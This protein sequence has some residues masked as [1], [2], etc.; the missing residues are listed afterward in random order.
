MA[1]DPI[2]I[3][4]LD[5]HQT[6]IDGYYYRLETA[7]GLRV[8]G[9]ARTGE[10]LE[11]L[12]ARE[13]ADVLLLDVAV[14]T[15]PTNSNSY[16]VLFAVPHLQARYPALSV[17][18]ISMHLDVALT[19]ALLES[20]ASGYILKDDAATIRVLP[21]VV[22]TVAA[23]GVHLSARVAQLLQQQAGAP[24]EALLTRR[25]HEVL[26]LCAAYPGEPGAQLAARLGVAP[27]TL[28]NLLSGA[29]ARLGVRN[30]VE[31]L[32]R[33]RELRLITPLTSD[34]WPPPDQPAP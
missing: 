24:G 16:P 1:I 14:P 11:A 10:E 23:G 8:V 30:L 19:K 12:L 2:R 34:P 33:A 22:R 31:A 9:A 18:V 5:D 20:G 27:S 7:P 28:R 13:P 17:L 15:S 25:Q 21:D 26:S 6:S 3:A 29:Y 4:I 32:Q